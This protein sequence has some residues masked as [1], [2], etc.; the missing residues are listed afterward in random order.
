MFF[1]AT[2]NGSMYW[3]DENSKD[4]FGVTYTATDF[5]KD[6]IEKNK[7]CYMLVSHYATQPVPCVK[8]GNI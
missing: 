6:C 4:G 1:E 8:K 2:G 3:S 5:M 7:P